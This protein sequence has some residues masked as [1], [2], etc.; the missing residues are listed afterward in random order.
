M[1]YVV[2]V[3]NLLNLFPQAKAAGGIR[4]SNFIFKVK[5]VDGRDGCVQMTRWEYSL[6]K[7]RQKENQPP[8]RDEMF[9]NL[10]K[11]ICRRWGRR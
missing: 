3:A 10:K 6:D 5:L 4:T 1:V 8:Q 11:K 7:L 2:L 9:H